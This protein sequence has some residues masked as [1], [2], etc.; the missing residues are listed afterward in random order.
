MKG[1]YPHEPKALKKINKGSNAYKTFYYYKDIQY[2]AHEPL[3]ERFRDFKAFMRRVK[4]AV[5]KDDPTKAERMLES[6]PVY[7]L[8]HIVRER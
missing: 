3:L 4:K 8:D 5:H 7:T 6:K 2:L 1:I